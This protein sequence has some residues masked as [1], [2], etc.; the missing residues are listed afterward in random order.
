[1]ESTRGNYDN[2][3]KEKIIKINKKMINESYINVAN[4]NSEQKN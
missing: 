2:Q 1:M 3:T 4:I